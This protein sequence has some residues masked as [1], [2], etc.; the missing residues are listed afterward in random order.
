M[1]FSQAVAEMLADKRIA[2]EDWSEK[3]PDSYCFISRDVLTVF[4]NGGFSTWIISRAD[5]VAE[6][7]KVV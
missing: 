6:D 4:I 2:R 5:L 7:W 3:N 1:N